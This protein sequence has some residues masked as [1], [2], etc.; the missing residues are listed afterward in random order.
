MR[1][2]ACQTLEAGLDIYTWRQP[3]SDLFK[4]KTYEAIE[5]W[6]ESD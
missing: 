2:V 6:R 5:N 1:P 4:I 3:K